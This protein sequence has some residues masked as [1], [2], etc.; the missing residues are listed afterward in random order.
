MF[1]PHCQTLSDTGQNVM[2]KYNALLIKLTLLATNQAQTRIQYTA[3]ES[4]QHSSHFFLHTVYM[5]FNPTCG[6]IVL[7]KTLWIFCHKHN[8]TIIRGGTK[9][10]Y[11]I[12][13]K[14]LNDTKSFLMLCYV[15]TM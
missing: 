15:S 5:Y 3:S 6:N 7:E 11:L 13:S 1:L 10:Q 8:I 9:R 2:L 12:T 4:E 14:Y